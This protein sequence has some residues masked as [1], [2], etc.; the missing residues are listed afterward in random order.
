MQFAVGFGNMSAI[1]YLIDEKG[2]KV[3]NKYLRFAA[4]AGHMDVVDYLIEEQGLKAEEDAFEAACRGGH[5]EICK[6]LAD[7]QG[8][9]PGKA[10]YLAALC[11][12][13]K[14]YKENASCLAYM[15]GSGLTV[16]E[17]KEAHLNVAKFL[18]ENGADPS[19]ARLKPELEKC[20]NSQL[21]AFLRKAAK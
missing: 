8:V 16:Q 10:F 15:S 18:V 2:A 7:E 13:T 1:K 20:D 9:D 3:R 11:M 14:D 12:S 19:D 21:V 5:L 17:L 6:Y 4:Y